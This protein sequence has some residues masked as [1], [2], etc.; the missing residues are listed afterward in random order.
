VRIVEP[1]GTANFSDLQSAIDA[2]VDGDVLLVGEG[3][4][5]GFT[6]DDK[7]LFIAAKPSASVKVDGTVVVRNLSSRNVVLC[8]LVLRGP[9]LSPLGPALVLQNDAGHVRLQGCTIQPVADSSQD[10]I[11][12]TGADK[13]VFASCTIAGADG[14][15]SYG[16]AGERGGVG[17]RADSSQVLLYDTQIFGGNVDSGRRRRRDAGGAAELFSS[18]LRFRE[19]VTA[20]PVA[21]ARS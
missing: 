8:G 9:A 15:D 3:T 19:Q 10:A 5:A 2:A 21:A 1:T 6:I 11:V 18:A 12:A 16:Y 20:A 17:L 7:D 14:R 4:Y 13:V